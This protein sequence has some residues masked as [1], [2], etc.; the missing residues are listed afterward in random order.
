MRI[1]VKIGI[2]FAA[3][4]ILIK[5]GMFGMGISSEDSLIPSIFINMFFLISAITV[6]LYLHKRKEVELGNAL[7]DIKN[8]MSAGIPYT[9]I[10]SVFIFLYYSKVD[11]NYV[12][13]KIADKAFELDKNLNNPVAL[14][15]IKASNPDFEVMTVKQI[16]KKVLESDQ[17]VY[18]AKSTAVFSLLAMAMY[19]TFNSIF[20][21]IIMRKIVFRGR[22]NVP[23]NEDL[24][25]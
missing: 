23:I 22:K 24:L 3:G 16:R 14:K 20:I 21:T 15:K 7:N 4:W 8:G 25:A 1:T 12:K 17:S 18:S 6:G 13:T 2:L 9:I 11:P 10:I 5:L 19:T